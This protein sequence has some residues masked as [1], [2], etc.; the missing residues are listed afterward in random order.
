[1]PAAED[2]RELAKELGRRIRCT[3]TARLPTTSQERLADRAGLHR[4]YMGR[5]ERGQVSI[6]VYNMVR[7]ANA[8]GI[9]PAELVRGLR[10]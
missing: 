1:V 5:V 9:D 3:R 7:I 10:T 4:A 2:T 8:L 6:S